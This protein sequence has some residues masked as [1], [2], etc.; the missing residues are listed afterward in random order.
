MRATGC[1]FILVLATVLWL[2]ILAVALGL[3][4]A[5][6]FLKASGLA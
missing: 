2:V 4:A 6:G 5:F 1:A 3:G